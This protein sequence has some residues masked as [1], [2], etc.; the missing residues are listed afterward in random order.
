MRPVST[1]AQ[2][3]ALDGAV[4]DGLGLPGIALMELASRGVA[5]VVDGLVER[6]ERVLVLCGPGNNGG[7]GWA[8][9]RCL[10]GW[11]HRVTV[12]AQ[13][14]PKG[15]DAAVMA[16]AARSAGVPVVGA[17][18]QRPQ[19][20]V[21]GLFG[22]GLT[23]AV[24]GV[25]AEVLKQLQ[26]VPSVA[27]DVPSGLNAD[28]G[29]GMG[30]VLAAAHTV[31]FGR[32]KLGM[33]LRDGPSVCGEI[34]VVDIGLEAGSPDD[35]H[36][37]A[38]LTEEVDLVRP[39][40][41]RNA[42]KRRAGDLLVVA[43]STAMAGAAVLAC[44]GALAAGVG[45]VRLVAPRGS[46][47]RL[48][49]LPPEVM[50][51]D[52]G[53]GDVL[54]ALPAAEELAQY[55]AVVAGPGLGGGAPLPSPVLS[56]LATWWQRAPVPLLFDADALVATSS[57]VA[58]CG[59]PRVLTPHE[60][61]AARLLGCTPTEVALD[62]VGAVQRLSARGTALL[63]G[64]NTLIADGQALHI[65]PTGHPVLATGGSGDVLAGFVGGLMARGL[66]G[67][68]AASNGAW[69]HGCAGESLAAQRLEGWSAS[70]LPNALRVGWATSPGR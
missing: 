70:D 55:S 4:I 38:W 17:V 12:W 37:A 29:E 11:G 48:A 51:Q 60:G 13:S 64:P 41:A 16:S 50:V 36:V 40:R 28:T 68:D 61:E 5:V 20:V 49:R 7:D 24:S 67:R 30:P 25:A 69:R 39:E 26:G 53:P 8:V 35:Q 22:T 59:A 66:S 62:R 31:T 47:P 42:H 3:R 34:H 9:A 43:G 1:A 18:D 46:F 52:G 19:L 57:G 63:K 56:A 14:E 65:N 6:G 58:G 44:E 21:D 54:G 45:L 33:Y 10:H 2:M 23:G 27:V 15:G 32:P